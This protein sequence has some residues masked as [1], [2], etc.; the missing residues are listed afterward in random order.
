MAL[1][2]HLMEPNFHNPSQQVVD[3]PPAW[4]PIFDAIGQASC[5]SQRFEFMPVNPSGKRPGDLLVLKEA[6]SCK[7]RMEG[8]PVDRPNLKLYP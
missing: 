7:A 4:E 2:K 5:I 3:Q 6:I 8:S 1:A